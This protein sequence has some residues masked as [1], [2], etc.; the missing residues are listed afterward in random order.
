MLRLCLVYSGN[1]AITTEVNDFKQ[2]RLVAGVNPET[3]YW[4]LQ[5]DSVFETPEAVMTYSSQGLSQMSHNF[6]RT[7][8]H[9]LIPGQFINERCPVL[10][11]NWEA[12]MID[13]D[14]EMLV[15][16]AGKAKELGVEMFV[17][18]DGWFGRRTDE[19]RGLGDW[20]CNLNKLP[21]GIPGFAGRIHDMG[22]KFG[23]WIEPEMVNEDSR[24]YE[25]HPDWC[26]RIPGRKPT[27]QR[28]QLILDFGRM[29]WLRLFFISFMRNL[30]M[31]RSITSSG[32]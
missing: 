28:Y 7:V 18:D 5:K 2:T 24:L 1:F 3:L 29:K 4:E 25:E 9:H 21:S 26:I 31:H 27:R 16:I 15:N 17:M 6:H 13:F 19:Y 32:I 10:I 22:L 20:Q 23:I 8:K 30:R 11:N 14:E 12:T